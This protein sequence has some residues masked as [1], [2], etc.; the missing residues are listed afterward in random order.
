[1][2]YRNGSAGLGKVDVALSTKPVPSWAAD[3]AGRTRALHDGTFMTHHHLRSAKQI[4]SDSCKFCGKPDFL[5]HRHWECPYTE[6]LRQNLPAELTGAVST[7]PVCTRKRRLVCW[8]PVTTG[9]QE[10]FSQCPPCH[11]S[12][13][14]LIAARFFEFFTDGCCK[15]PHI[16]NARLVCFTRNRCFDGKHVG[17]KLWICYW[18]GGSGTMA[19]NFVSRADCSGHGCPP[20]YYASPTSQ[21]LAWQCHSSQAHAEDASWTLRM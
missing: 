7:W 2:V 6:Q 1:M 13:E 8:T 5:T 16:P 9:V 14:Q 10:C 3:E 11:A 4:G 12:M 20:Q 19:N 21:D 18:R 15:S 17:T